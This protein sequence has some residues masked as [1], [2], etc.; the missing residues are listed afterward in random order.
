MNPTSLFRYILAFFLI[1]TVAAAPLPGQ[2]GEGSPQGT[3][4]DLQM[5]DFEKRG[6][7]KRDAM[8]CSCGDG[9]PQ[10][11]NSQ[12]IRVHFSAYAICVASG[13]CTW[14]IIPDALR[15]PYLNDVFQRANQ[16]PWIYHP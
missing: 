1:A 3:S 6:I 16:L 13:R 15:S 12:L 11:R 2:S 14:A 8:T 9:C 10:R 4:F 7:E 5:Q